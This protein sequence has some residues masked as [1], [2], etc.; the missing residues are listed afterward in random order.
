MSQLE[1]WEGSHFMV[2]KD[3]N[4]SSKY[5]DL[6]YTL[7]DCSQ[8]SSFVSFDS[9]S[10]HF[11]FKDFLADTNS[12]FPTDNSCSSSDCYDSETFSITHENVHSTPISE[13]EVYD[14]KYL[15]SSGIKYCEADTRDPDSELQYSTDT[16]L[17]HTSARDVTYIY[18]ES[19]VPS[20]C[21]IFEVNSL[22]NV[23][24]LSDD[25]FVY[26]VSSNELV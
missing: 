11:E 21:D 5:H 19:S 15:L 14:Q 1:R 22:E 24:D 16:E 26:N 12:L 8:S 4:G 3:I 7:K 20:V 18:E 13:T 2:P 25:T 10:S 17:T 9:S 23:S 6:V